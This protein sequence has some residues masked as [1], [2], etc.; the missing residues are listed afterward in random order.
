MNIRM[1][2]GEIVEN[3]AGPIALALWAEHIEQERKKGLYPHLPSSIVACVGS[4][5]FYADSATVTAGKLYWDILLKKVVKLKSELAQNTDNDA[6]IDSIVKAEACVDYGDPNGDLDARQLVADSLNKIARNGLVLNADNICFTVGATAALNTT[7]DIL[8]KK[9]ADG[10]IITPSP[11]YWIYRGRNR[12]NN[13]YTFSL[14]D[15]PGYQLTAMAIATCIQNAKRDNKKI[16]AFIF[17]D[18]NNPLGTTVDSLEWKKIADVLAKEKDALIILD[19]SYA[20]LKLDFIPYVSLLDLVPE[21]KERIIAIYSATKGLSMAGER[22]S[23]TVIPHQTLAH[24]FKFEVLT[25]YLHAPRSS[26][27]A[28]SKGMANRNSHDRQLMC[29]FYGEQVK[30]MEKQLADLGLAMPDRNYHVSGGFY[31][32]ADFSKFLGA[33]LPKEARALFGIKNI[34]A[35]TDFDIAAYLIF[36]AGVYVAPLSFGFNGDSAQGYMRISCCVGMKNLQEM[37]ERLAKQL[38]RKMQLDSLNKQVFFKVPTQP[39][40]DKTGTVTTVEST[41]KITCKL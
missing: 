22:L 32:L 10:V 19:L 17:C 5:T 39:Q 23:F 40:P 18:P 3:N 31:V 6:A 13:L 25:S 14:L 11:H 16:S 27:F 15:S 24:Q 33:E 1:P 35:K 34:V 28:Y 41:A 38:A 2:S 29:N 9:S 26:Q 37:M 8:R 7:F 21:L 36:T 30:Y 12:E 4:P 20:D